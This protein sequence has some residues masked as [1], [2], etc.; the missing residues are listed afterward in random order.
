MDA[1]Y[2]FSEADVILSLD[3]DFMEQGPGHLRYAREFAQRRSVQNNPAGANRLYVAETTPSVTGLNA[4]HRLPV[5]PSA[6]DDLARALLRAIGA[7]IE[8]GSGAL[9]PEMASWISAVAR[10]LKRAGSRALVL[11]GPHQSSAI[12]AMAHA[13]NAVLGSI[14]RT[15]V[16]VEPAEPLASFGTLKELAGDMAAGRVHMLMS[17]DSNPV[18]TAPVD[19][20]FS[21]AMAKVAL[22]V[23]CGLYRDETAEISHWHVPAAHPLES[24]GDF[25]AS[26]GTV[27]LQQ[28]LLEPLYG[29]KTATEV[30]SMMT[31]E[32]AQSAHDLLQDFWRGRWGAA[33]F[34]KN[35]RTS[36]HE[37]VVAGTAAAVLRPALLSGWARHLPNPAPKQE[38]Y[39]IVFREDA[40]IGDGRDANNGWLQELPKP[41][42]KLTWDNAAYVSPATAKKLGVENEKN[43]EL[44]LNGR[45]VL[46]PVWILP[47]QPDDTVTVHWG[48][49]RTKAGRVGDGRGF[50]AYALLPSWAAGFSTGLQIT[51]AGGKTALACTQH[52][53]SMEDR[54]L[55]REATFEEFRK[56][57][58]FAQKMR[59]EPSDE[60]SLYQGPQADDYAWAMTIDL[61]ACNGC[62]ACVTG[63]QS[64]NNI[65]VVGKDQVIKG[66]EMHWIRVDRYY[67]G[68]PENP[69]AA[70]QPINCMHCE[71]A[72]CEPVCPVGATVHSD[73][74]INEM[75]YNRCVGTRY[76]SNNC[77]YKVRRFNFF[78]YAEYESP[79]SKLMNNP[80]VTVRM[81]GVMEKCT[82]CIQRVQTAKIEASK[83]DRTVRDGEIVTACQSACPTQAIVFGN[84][85][86]PNSRV[87]R[88]KNDPRNYGI[89]TDLGTRPRTTYLAR[90]RNPNPELS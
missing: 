59:H 5:R 79:L 17:L 72:P 53:A 33:S 24:W 87:S 65:P 70:F 64:E 29:G 8:E 6:M 15:V 60:H 73:E 51:R 34:E 26:D 83:E 75:V 88:L 69:E 2:R 9:S 63:C 46:A 47:G 89:L 90:L 36:L 35:W 74:G 54:A 40:T 12:H 67:Q 84:L 20:D 44:S 1:R 18:Y 76:C 52:H 81:R 57:P 28:P 16:Y 27:S 45:R 7:S 48:Y 80:D 37:G 86:D 30:L 10:D 62:N 38:G 66:R 78:Q 85:K 71:N 55:I 42:S 43:V 14:G 39:E 32:S 31:D 11:A 23:H 61:N 68:S 21:A 13:A 77:P 22:R 50:N 19:L 3:G 4:D 56:D 25:R 58:H 82:Y 49:G 41:V